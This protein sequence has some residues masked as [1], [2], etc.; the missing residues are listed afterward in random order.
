VEFRRKVL[1]ADPGTEPYLAWA[2]RRV[3][4]LEALR[5]S[6]GLQA[7]F[8]VMSP[9]SGVLV[10]LRYAGGQWSVRVTGGAAGRT[11][12]LNT[13]DGEGAAFRWYHVKGGLD[14]YAEAVRTASQA[15]RQENMSFDG[16]AL[17]YCAVGS[18]DVKVMRKQKIVAS[19][20]RSTR[21]ALTA[22]QIIWLTHGVMVDLQPSDSR[23]DNTRSV[24]DVLEFNFGL[25]DSGKRLYVSDIE[26]TLGTRQ[27]TAFDVSTTDTNTVLSQ[28]WQSGVPQ[29]V[30]DFY[31]SL[32]IP[33]TLHASGHANPDQV[34]DALAFNPDTLIPESGLG[35]HFFAL[36]V[37]FAPLNSGY[38]AG[39][40]P[41]IYPAWDP[42]NAVP[43]LVVTMPYASALSKDVG[44]N[45]IWTVGERREIRR[46]D[47]DTL[48][49]ELVEATDRPAMIFLTYSGAPTVPYTIN[50]VQVIGG[51]NNTAASDYGAT[52]FPA[53]GLD[54]PP[55]NVAQRSTSVTV[56]DKVF[57]K[58]TGYDL[59]LNA[60]RDAV[61]VNNGS[62]GHTIWVGDTWSHD[63]VSLANP[64]IFS[65]HGELMWTGKD[66]S[67]WDYYELGILKQHFV[68]APTADASSFATYGAVS[69]TGFWLVNDVVGWRY[70]RPTSVK[71]AVYTTRETYAGYSG[72][73][74]TST[75]GRSTS[76]GSAR[77][78]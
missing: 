7:M 72:R 23:Y 71:A 52:L 33:H 66:S 5:R 76:R 31:A 41:Q 2:L 78:R 8:R 65:P 29:F 26:P 18:A 56:L 47:P 63:F 13:A 58:P 11:R 10:H 45:Y 46:L 73:T 74:H 38:D 42:F 21:N 35:P 59:L 49:W 22:E 44:T 75:V 62:T 39:T 4:A 43:L 50:G 57:T 32:V 54:L 69:P 27:V 3:R 34:P 12:R 64:P 77:C 36:P 25:S 60:A 53:M 6:T 40:G 20:T 68:S 16:S 28:T 1:Q 30:T 67:G 14:G 17:A 48:T 55:T 15:N 9:A 61:W 70:D 24:W 37:R 19:Y 51:A